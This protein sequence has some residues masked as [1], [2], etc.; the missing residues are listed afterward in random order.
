MRRSACERA[1]LL[2]GFV[3]VVSCSE[4]VDPPAET[5][6]VRVSGG[7]MTMGGDDLDPCDSTRYDGTTLVVACDPE[8]QSEVIR[9]RVTLRDYC[10]DSTEVTIDQYRH[11]ESRGECEAPKSTNAGNSDTEGFIEK[12]YNN[13]E[14]YGRYPVTG[15][16][17]EEAQKFCAFHGGRLPTEAEW[18]FAA[19]SGGKRDHVLD[20]ELLADARRDCRDYVGKVTFGACTGQTI[21]A[22]RS[23]EADVALGVYDLAGS[24]E[25]WVADEWD[26]L[27]YCDPDQQGDGLYDLFDITDQPRTRV[28]PASSANIPG[29]FVSDP[30]CLETGSADNP[31]CADTRDSC[32]SRC[33][34][35]ER[36]SG[37]NSERQDQ[38]R[39]AYC[40]DEAGFPRG[41]SG[42]TQGRCNPEDDEHCEEAFPTEYGI[43]P[44][45]VDFCDCMLGEEGIETPETGGECVQGCFDVYRSC[46][47][48]DGCLPEEV[49]IAWTVRGGNDARP[50]PWCAARQIGAAKAHQP[51]KPPTDFAERSKKSRGAHVVRGGNFQSTNPCRLRVTRRSWDRSPS[52]RRGFRCAYDVGNAS[53]ATG[54]NRCP[55][56]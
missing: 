32:V 29:R 24:V 36:G 46:T 25:E 11:C 14:T 38:W 56:N 6:T 4:G 43:N 49:Q 22:V 34:N 7:T 28:T 33:V 42:A 16:T 30:S 18:E 5:S 26:F 52:N 44:L 51:H 37:T 55:R 17:W 10:I 39:R 45:C 19:R 13:H 41:G 54:A 48:R 27:A 2:L 15:V 31:G 50:V 20:D 47:R 8:E 21:R 35:L 23:G 3:A 53:R 40:A 12:Y 9:N 1:T